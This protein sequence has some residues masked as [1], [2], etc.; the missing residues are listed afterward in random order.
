MNKTIICVTLF[1][2]IV[3]LEGCSNL[4]SFTRAIEKEQQNTTI[5]IAQT[6]SFNYQ[7]YALILANYVNDRGLVNYSE[8][9]KN[10]ELLD[11]FNK[12]LAQVNFHTYESW[13]ESEQ[14]A[15]LI[16]AY[17]ALTLQSII[18]REPLTKSIRDIPGVWKFRK[19]QVAGS[20]KTLDNIEHDTIRKDF[21][22]P[23]IHAALVCAAM[24]CPP[25]R[26][27]PYLPEKLDEQ[28]DEQVNKFISSPQGFR[29]DRQKNKVYLS[30]IFKWYGQDWID[31]Y[32]IQDKFTGNQKE[33]AVLNFL[34]DYLSPE[35]R[36]YLEN[37]QYKIIYLDYDWSLNKQ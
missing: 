5:S 37:G 12:S 20:A 19:F 29:L 18:A 30:S 21:S 10:R 24:S 16:N 35:E 4:G 32:Y 6:E 3:A 1:L 15:F 17:N 23:R 14:L 9:Q 22:E 8:L 27:E 2:A 11:R 13:S 33:K 25:L 36:Q 26:N 28:L 31:N 7:D 34:S